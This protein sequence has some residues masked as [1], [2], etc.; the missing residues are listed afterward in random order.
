MTYV[1]PVHTAQLPMHHGAARCM[2]SRVR[3]STVFDPQHHW[4]RP[5][6]GLNSAVVCVVSAHLFLPHSSRRI[7]W[8][9]RRHY[10]RYE[11]RQRP[12]NIVGPSTT[13]SHQAPRRVSNYLVVHHHTSSSASSSASSNMMMIPP[14][15]RAGETPNRAVHVR[16]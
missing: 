11:C 2:R 9:K 8:R 16:Q 4:R 3:Y 10:H 15:I 13:Q 7:Y 14:R 5:F 12:L 6:Y 1:E